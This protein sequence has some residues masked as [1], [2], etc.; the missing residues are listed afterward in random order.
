MSLVESPHPFRLQNDLAEVPRLRDEFAQACKLAGV[1]E[2]TMQKAML[3]L[4]ELLNNAIEHGCKCPTDCVS[5]WWRIS[6]DEIVTEATDPGEVLT[7]ADFTES[8]PTDFA[9]T[10]RGAG[11]FLVQALVD[12]LQVERAGSGGTTVRVVIRRQAAA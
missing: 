3:V 9:E 8:D 5:G 4:T 2:D 10:G 7:K 11:L 12:D 6:P 1:D